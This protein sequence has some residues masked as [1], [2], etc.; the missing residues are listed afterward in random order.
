MD[1]SSFSMAQ[2]RGPPVSTQ[3]RDNFL[4]DTN[5][6]FAKS[7]T[8]AAN[9]YKGGTFATKT[10]NMR[11]NDKV[12]HEG[13]NKNLSTMR[14]KTFTPAKAIKTANPSGKD[15]LYDIRTNGSLNDQ[16]R[17]KNTLPEMLNDRNRNK[18]YSSNAWSKNLDMMRSAGQS[19]DEA[20]NAALLTT[21]TNIPKAN[22]G[23]PSADERLRISQEVFQ[24]PGRTEGDK[25]LANV[26]LRTS[27]EKLERERRQREADVHLKGE[28]VLQLGR[29][30]LTAN[31]FGEIGDCDIRQKVVVDEAIIE[32]F[33]RSSERNRTEQKYR[34]KERYE[35]NAKAIVDDEYADRMRLYERS[36]YYKDSP[37]TRK[38]TYNKG[39]FIN[40]FKKGEVYDVFPDDPTSHTA[41]ILVEADRFTKK[42]VRT[43]ATTDG[44][45]LY[46]IQKRD[47]DDI[48]ELDGRKY[49]K[50]MIMLEIPY[51]H[52]DQGFR[53]RVNNAMGGARR[54]NGNLLDLSY[55][56]LVQLSEY[57]HVNE[58]N[59]TRLK[60]NKLYNVIRDYEWDDRLNDN[61]KDK[62]FFIHPGLVKEER[63]ILRHKL[64]HHDRG[65]QDAS[66]N[67]TIN[68][69]GNANRDYIN[70]NEIHP[71]GHEK[72]KDKPIERTKTR[73]SPFNKAWSFENNNR[74]TPFIGGW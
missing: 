5:I 56:D 12:E 61:F 10:T 33:G 73:N 11:W 3:V 6:G 74:G 43:F 16:N 1:V 46:A 39:D 22:V 26:R 49:D 62:V 53:N 27:P 19:M 42:P 24:R 21:H 48:Y 70:A 20:Y 65:R 15:A 38:K 57:I 50:D 69:A 32:E 41:P 67:Y 60:N 25:V 35:A 2:Y 64:R 17:L 8:L 51:Q 13:V 29:Y 9:A 30:D 44:K 31:K 40:L 23:I 55:D 37:G 58:S 47:A 28:A 7:S 52:M 4:L 63:D 68:E 36:D 71:I 72:V 18:I 59:T 45:T 14:R 66:D 54:N 34:S